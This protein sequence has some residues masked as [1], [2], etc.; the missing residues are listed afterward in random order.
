M[1][2]L[3]LISDPQPPLGG[4]WLWL[5]LIDDSPPLHGLL[6]HQCGS[7]S[8]CLPHSLSF[9]SCLP[10][11]SIPAA[12]LIPRR[13]FSVQACPPQTYGV[14]RG[15]GNMHSIRSSENIHVTMAL[16]LSP[17]YSY[18]LRPSSIYSVGCAAGVDGRRRGLMFTGC[19]LWMHWARRWY[20]RSL[21]LQFTS[22][23]EKQNK[24]S[25]GSR[26]SGVRLTAWVQ[27]PALLL[28]SC[29]SL[30]KPLNVLYLSFPLY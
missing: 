24:F 13:D 19:G 2:F 3:W 14:R 15:P 23:L 17:Y 5:R 26:D 11:G 30:T 6:S 4:C 8:L 18:E 1:V 29:V 25:L 10:G 28:T 16:K 27:I 20:A 9:R 21:S 22:S 7:E 12:M